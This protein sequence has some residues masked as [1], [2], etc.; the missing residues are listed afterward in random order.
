MIRQM[1][2]TKAMGVEGSKGAWWKMK[3][4]VFTWCIPTSANMLSSGQLH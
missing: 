1:L 3:L 2:M 4:L